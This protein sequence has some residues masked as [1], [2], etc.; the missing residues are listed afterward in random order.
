MLLQILYTDLMPPFQLVSQENLLNTYWILNLSPVE[1]T[2]S[3]HKLKNGKNHGNCD[4]ILE[5]LIIILDFDL[6]MNRKKKNHKYL[7]ISYHEHKPRYA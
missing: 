1:S 2:A 5:E 6:S 3:L 7:L 4:S